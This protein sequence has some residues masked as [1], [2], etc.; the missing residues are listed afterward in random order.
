MINEPRPPQA[1]SARR[2]WLGLTLVRG[3]VAY[4]T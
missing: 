2:L 1:T 3:G 4:G